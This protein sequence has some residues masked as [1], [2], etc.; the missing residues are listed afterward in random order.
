M[1]PI[2]FAEHLAHHPVEHGERSIGQLSF[3]L[4]GEDHQGS[5]PPLIIEAVEVLGAEDCGLAGDSRVA[6]PVNTPFPVRPDADCPDRLKP[7]DDP[8]KILLNGRLWPFPQPS[9]RGASLI[10]GNTDQ[11]IQLLLNGVIHTCGQLFIGLLSSA[12][13]RHQSDL[14]EHG[15]RR[16]QNRILLQMDHHGANDSLTT[17]G[18]DRLVE[19]DPSHGPVVRA[20]KRLH[21]KIG[22]QLS[23][24]LP[25]SRPALA[26]SPRSRWNRFG[27]DRR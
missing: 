20:T 27:A 16:E 8:G 18:T 15:S 12:R 22:L 24:V 25:A 7:L 13:P 1:L 21:P 23:E 9:K 5:K 26:H 3:H 2:C 11:C 17:V 6:G 14:F 4:S 19:S 10:V